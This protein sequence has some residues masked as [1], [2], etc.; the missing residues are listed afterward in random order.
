MP[1]RKFAGMQRA[2]RGGDY[3]NG[4]S[5]LAARGDSVIYI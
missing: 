5:S 4:D 1:T 3:V 2:A